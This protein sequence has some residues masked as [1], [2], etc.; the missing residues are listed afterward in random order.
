[1]KGGVEKRVYEIGRRLAKK[2]EV[3]WYGLDW[4]DLTEIKLHKVGRWLSLYSGGRR[5]IRGAVY[6][7]VKLLS[8]FN[9]SYDIV[10][11]QQFPYLSCFSIK[12][13]SALKNIPLVVTWH[14]VWGEYWMEYL[15]SLGVFGAQIEKLTSKLT[16]NNISVSKLTQK[17]LRSLG[18]T[19]EFIPNGIDFE[20]ISKVKKAEDEYDVVFVGRLI[21]EKNVELLLEALVEVKKNMPDISA[22]IVG[23]GPE[24]DQLEKLAFDLGL[25]ENVKFVGFLESHDEVISYMKS[26]KAFVLPSKREGFGIVALEANASGLPVVTVNYPMN[27]VEGL[28]I[29]GYTGFVSQPSPTSLANIY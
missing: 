23:D 7:A 9:G 18:V 27:A 2:H 17:R 6:F 1:M 11:C 19:S 24:K 21:K 28:I 25:S 8:K 16:T 22:L 26:S 5:S 29:H 4:R 12:F 13:H 20:K 14:E 10:D 3:Y 15:G